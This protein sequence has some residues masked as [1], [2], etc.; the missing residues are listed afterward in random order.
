MRLRVWLTKSVLLLLYVVAAAVV[1]R[2]SAEAGLLD[3]LDSVKEK[4]AAVRGLEFKQPV[5]AKVASKTDIIIVLLEELNKQLTPEDVEGFETSFEKFGVLPPDTD[6][7][8]L[9]V[10]LYS[11]EAAGL[12]DPRGK[13][14]WINEEVGGFFSEIALSHE[15]T[16][17]LQDQHFDIM[18]LPLEEK[19]EDDLILATSAVLE[20]DASISMFEYFLGDP[21][22]VDEIIDAGV[23]DMM[24][25]ML[26]AYGGALG[27]APGLIKAI[28]VF[29]YT[30]G[31]EFVQTVKKRGGWD[32]VNH[33]YRV[34]PLS[35][36]QIL[37]PKEKFLDNDPPV[38]VDLPDLSPLLGDQWEPLPA[39]VLGEFQLRVVLEE[40]LGD[41]EE[42]ESAAAGWDGDR[43]RCYKSPDA[44]LLTWVAVWDTEED[45]SE[46]FSAYKAILRKK[47]LSETASESEA[48][49]SYSVTDSGEVSHISVDENQ[50][51]VLES[52]PAD[53]LSEAEE[54]LWEA[55]LT[56]LPKADT[57]RFIE[58]EPVPREGMSA[59][60]YRPKGEIKGDRFVSEELGFEMSLPGQEWTFLDELPF[61]MMAV[62]MIHSR[63][64]AAVNVM[65]QSLGGIL[66]LQQVAEMVKAGL[67]AQGSQYRVIEEGKIQVGGEEGYQVTAEITFGKPQRVRQVLVQHA[68]KTFI[69]TSSGYSEDFDAL[70]EEIAAMERG[71]VLHAEEPVPAEEKA[72]E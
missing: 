61:P 54:L 38:S 5:E 16:H 21:A 59:A 12:Y 63:R 29:P 46:F 48:P 26:P 18:S 24:E 51:I 27:D 25:A 37:H 52:L 14:L 22:L 13:R 17:A 19:G 45:A 20:G 67:G 3:K 35:T 56:E 8:V 40:L 42:A 23:V 70:S 53:L 69:I 64:Y 15:L 31:M 60:V 1:T 10:E 47:Y 49:G 55:G 57:S 6:L 30:Y 4:T 44:V 34:R 32:T 71:F 28:V 36:E 50:T 72:P 2:G 68:G 65:V 39:N 33:L 62:G 11:E 7:M 66:S 43:Y 9:L 41:P 58:A